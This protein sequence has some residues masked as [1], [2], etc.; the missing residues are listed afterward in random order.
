MGWTHRGD[1]A[2]PPGQGQE[3]YSKDTGL[4]PTRLHSGKPVTG[5]P[6]HSPGGGRLPGRVAPQLK[7]QE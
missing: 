1:P 7:P 4:S 6:V 2:D 3:R 5:E